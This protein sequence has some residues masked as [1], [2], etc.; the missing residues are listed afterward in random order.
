MAA[1]IGEKIGIERN[2]LRRQ[3]A[4]GG[5]EEFCL[6]F[7][8][9]LFLRLDYIGRGKFDLLQAL[10]VDFAGGSF[11]RLLT[12][13]NRS[14][15]IYAGRLCRSSLRRVR[16]SIS[17]S[18]EG[19]HERDELFDFVVVAQDDGGLRNARETGELCFDF[20]QFD[21][22]AANLDLIVDPAMEHDFAVAVDLHR[23]AGPVQK[24]GSGA[25]SRIRIGDEFLAG[26]P[27]AAQIA[28]RHPGPAD[29]KLAFDAGRKKFEAL[30][31]HI[32]SV[33][34]DRPPDR[35]LNARPHFRDRRDDRRLRRAIGIEDFAPRPAPAIGNRRRAGLAAKD[36]QPQGSRHRAAAASKGSAPCPTP[37]RYWLREDRELVGLAHHFGG[38]HEKARAGKVRKPDFL[39]G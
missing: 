32:A 30:A 14:G 19:H 39:H 13:S 36:D 15:T 37:S 38:R 11:G 2:G 33:I 22:K 24:T 4:F 26:Q 5:V 34:R 23:I 25:S 6:G 35:D 17:A 1:E 9:R 28:F 18:K 29:E 8:A 31:R 10:A 3:H 21:A 20:A 12:S 27:V 16:A 7:V